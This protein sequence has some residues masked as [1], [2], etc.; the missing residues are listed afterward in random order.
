MGTLLCRKIVKSI[1]KSAFYTCYQISSV[2][3]AYKLHGEKKGSLPILVLHGLLGSKRNWESLSR[4][5]FEIIDRTVMA[6]DA[7]NHGESEHHDTHTYF[8]LA[9]DVKH[10]MVKLSV[11]R[12]ELVG[13]SM[14]G[15]T[16]MVLALNE[17]FTLD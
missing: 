11:D 8:D 12:A 5:M 13:H 1:I 16:A 14:G 3:L 7:R 6:V 17:V 9:S 10:L 4:K 15:R 2:D